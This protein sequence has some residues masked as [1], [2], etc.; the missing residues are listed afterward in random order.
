MQVAAGHVDD[1]ALGAQGSRVER[2]EL[3]LHPR[4]APLGLRGTVRL[5]TPRSCLAVAAWESL[6]GGRSSRHF[7]GTAESR[8]DSGASRTV[9][10][11]PAAIRYS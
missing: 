4:P 5:G 8:S 9:L 7:D 6:S 3:V 10:P 1:R 2:T 11:Q